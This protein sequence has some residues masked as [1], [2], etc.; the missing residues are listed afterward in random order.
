MKMFPFRPE[1]G[2]HAALERALMEEFLSEQGLSFED[3]PSLGH[4]QC[5]RLT[6]EAAAYAAQQLGELAYIGTRGDILH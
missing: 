2:P 5:Q 6:L 4:D 1:K 3:L